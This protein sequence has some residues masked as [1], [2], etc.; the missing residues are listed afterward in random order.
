MSAPPN[1]NADRLRYRSAA[2][3]PQTPQRNLQFDITLEGDNNNEDSRASTPFSDLWAD[4]AKL[5]AT[6]QG[7]LRL[8]ATAFQALL[9][10]PRESRDAHPPSAGHSLRRSRSSLATRVRL[11][12][13]FGTGSRSLRRHGMPMYALANASED[14]L[15]RNMVSGK[16]T[17]RTLLDLRRIQVRFEVRPMSL[18]SWISREDGHA[19]VAFSWLAGCEISAMVV[20]ASVSWNLRSVLSTLIHG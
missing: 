11:D 9:L 20:S 7:A 16:E 15:A 3:P 2:P 12:F 1:A 17:V 14:E 10:V 5:Y 6:I 8:S 13:V 19:C 4:E 18:Y